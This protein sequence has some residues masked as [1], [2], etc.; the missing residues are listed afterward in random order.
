MKKLLFAIGSIAAMIVISSC[1]TDNLE[2]GKTE[3]LINKNQILPS[4]TTDS[5]NSTTPQNLLEIS[6]KDKNQG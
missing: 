6:D 3:N 4:V 5:L 2:E 1:S